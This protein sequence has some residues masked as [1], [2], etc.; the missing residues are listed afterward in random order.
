MLHRAQLCHSRPMSSGCSSVSLSVCDVQ[1]PWSHRLENLENNF[2]AGFCSGWPQHGRSGRTG[3]PAKLGW[4]RGWVMST[5][6]CNISETVQ[7][8]S[9]VIM[10]D[11][12]EVA[13]VLFDLYQN[14]WPW[15]TLNGRNAHMRKTIVLP[16]PP[17]E[18]IEWRLSHTISSTM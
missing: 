4:N 18:T 12:L 9:K 8:R 11:F 7:D 5:K 6:P 15:M 17:S 1:V 14:Q 16:S 3:I 10:K 2:M 13:Y